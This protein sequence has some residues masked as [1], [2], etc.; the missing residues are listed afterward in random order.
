MSRDNVIIELNIAP[1]QYNL[2]SVSTMWPAVMFAAKRK[3]RVI[4]RTKI[5]VVSIITRK[6]F[7]HSGAPSGKKCAVDFFAEYLKE[8]ISIL[9]H[10]GKPIESVSRR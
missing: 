6:G 2:T 1:A 9:I 7:S 10:I 3:D 5:L 8:E 4:G